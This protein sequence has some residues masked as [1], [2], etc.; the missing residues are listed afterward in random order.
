MS[1]AGPRRSYWC[2][3]RG[4]RS[5]R[6]AVRRRRQARRRSV[7][8]GGGVPGSGVGESGNKRR[9]WFAGLF[10]VPRR[11]RERGLGLCGELATAASRWRPR[12]GSGLIGVAWRGVEAPARGDRGSR[13]LRGRHVKRRRSRTWLGVTQRGGGRRGA[14]GGAGSR[15]AGR[16]EKGGLF[17]KSENSKD[18]NVKQG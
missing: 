3:Q 2:G 4:R 7:D 10:V 1:F 18:Q 13:S 6:E 17:A 5:R 9:G 11:A 8:G 12:G 14:V 16:K 15:G